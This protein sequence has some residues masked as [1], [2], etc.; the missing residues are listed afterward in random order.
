LGCDAPGD[1]RFDLPSGQ[2]FSRFFN[3]VSCC[4]CGSCDWSDRK[5]KNSNEEKYVYIPPRVQSRAEPIHKGPRSK[6]P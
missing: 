6:N 3:F 4:D 2:S 5:R 1:C